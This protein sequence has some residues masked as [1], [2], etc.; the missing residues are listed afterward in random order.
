MTIAASG[1]RSACFSLVVKDTGLLAG[2]P[3]ITVHTLSKFSLIKSENLINEF[4]QNNTKKCI[5]MYTVHVNISTR[6]IIQEIEPEKSAAFNI[7]TP[8]TTVAMLPE[9]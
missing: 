6:I 8:S 2:I 4:S 1:H 9:K 3:K 5:Y 7:K